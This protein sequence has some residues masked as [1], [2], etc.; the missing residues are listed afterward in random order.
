MLSLLTELSAI[1][2]VLP[3][4]RKRRA[5]GLKSFRRLA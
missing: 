1:R 2:L 3:Y 4:C 5:T